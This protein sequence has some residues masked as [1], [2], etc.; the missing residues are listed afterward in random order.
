[1][2]GSEGCEHR[3]GPAARMRMGPR[4]AQRCELLH[5][6]DRGPRLSSTA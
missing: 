6:T 1:M 2:V 4:P 3:I 5:P